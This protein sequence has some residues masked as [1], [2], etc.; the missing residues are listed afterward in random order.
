[1][2]CLIGGLG[3]SG[4]TRGVAARL[5]E[6]NPAL[7]TIG[8]VSATGDFIPGIRSES[9]MWEVGLFDRSRYDDIIAIDAITAVDATLTLVRGYGI[10]SGPTGGAAYAAALRHL[11]D[12]QG[13]EGP[14][15]A[16]VLICDRLEPYLSY[17]RARSPHLFGLHPQD[18]VTTDT[19]DRP[20]SRSSHAR[21]SA[22]SAALSR[23]AAQPGPAPVSMIISR[24]GGTLTTPDRQTAG[25]PRTIMPTAGSRLPPLTSRSRTR[26]GITRDSA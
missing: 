23:P 9:E 25:Q 26:V 11:S 5:K 21:N 22:S 8:V 19:G 15:T 4:S 18:R 16:V 1:V 24:S 3:T 6:H 17:L 10:L 2:D 14:L 12:R 7:N 20:R 13:Y